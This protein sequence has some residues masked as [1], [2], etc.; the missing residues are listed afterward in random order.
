MVGRYLRV[1][2]NANANAQ[3]L[4]SIVVPAYKAEKTIEACIQSVCAQTYTNWE[5]IVIDDASPD[6]TSEIVTYYAEKDA[7]LT[8]VRNDPNL[9]VCESRNKGLALAQGAWIAFLD[10][11]DMW[12]AEKLARQLR[13]AEAV[14]GRF[15]YTGLSYVDFR[16]KPLNYAFV[17]TQEIQLAEYKRHNV[18]TCS[19]VLVAKKAI[20]GLRFEGENVR[21]DYL[22][23]LRV[24]S[25]TGSAYCVQEPLTRYRLSEQSRSSNKRKMI[26]QTYRTHRMQGEGVL[27]ASFYCVSHMLNAY[28]QKYRHL[29]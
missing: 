15:L 3:A 13:L 25:R 26:L 14:N 12:E 8:L 20:E 16:G 18:I 4:V 29:K 10:S 17:P 27:T 24:L 23:W 9:G 21:E 11:D 28:W 1:E 2:K 7:R 5:M 6:R 22:F 19:S